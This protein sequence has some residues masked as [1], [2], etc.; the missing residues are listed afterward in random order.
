MKAA[1]ILGVEKLRFIEP[2][3]AELTNAGFNELLADLP[4]DR[5]L[6]LIDGND[7]PLALAFHDAGSWTAG[8]F[9]CRNPSVAAIEH[10]EEFNG[11]IYQEDRKI[12]VEAVREYY[13]NDIAANV[14]PAVDDLNKDR[15]AII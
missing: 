9:I 15:P 14:T 12:W 13:S 7:E 2:S 10:F 11:E 4:A 8:T 3:Y 1:E 5:T 6:L